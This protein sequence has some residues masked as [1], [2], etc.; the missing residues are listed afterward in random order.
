MTAN[1][2]VPEPWAGIPKDRHSRQAGRDLLEQL[3][4]FPAYA[5]FG[6]HE[7]G[8]VAARPRQAFDKAGTDRI[9]GDR[10]YDR[11]GAGRLLADWPHAGSAMARMTSGASAT[12]SAAYLRMRS[13]LPAPQR[14]SMRMLR[15]MIQP[16]CCSPCGNAARRA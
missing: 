2:L 9:A 8:D 7:T 16:D 3:Q 15:P 4:P 6:G 12:N 10:E 1:W 13:A 14:M 11:H 5:V